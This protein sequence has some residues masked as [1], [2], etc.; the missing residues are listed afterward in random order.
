M[1]PEAHWIACLAESKKAQLYRD[2][3]S[4]TSSRD[5]LR[6]DVVIDRIDF[7]LPICMC[8]CPC[9]CTCTHNTHIHTWGRVGRWEGGWREKRVK[10]KKKEKEAT[11]SSGTQQPPTPPREL[12]QHLEMFWLLWRR[13][14]TSIW[15]VVVKDAAQSSQ[16]TEKSMNYKEFSSDNVRIEMSI[17]GLLSWASG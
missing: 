3:F 7:E 2:S 9:A 13:G 4:K 17:V 16:S 8:V 1:T 12:W 14:M 11:K 5:W 15:R 10:W 6:R